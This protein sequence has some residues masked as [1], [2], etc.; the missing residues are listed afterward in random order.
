[1]SKEVEIISLC[2]CLDSV[3]LPISSGKTFVTTKTLEHGS[4]IAIML[5]IQDLIQNEALSRGVWDLQLT[6]KYF[7]PI[8]S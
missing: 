5:V 7:L 1:M 6:V 2:S 8:F 4:D 3:A